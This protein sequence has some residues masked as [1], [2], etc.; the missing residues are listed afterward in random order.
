MA[1]S[2]Q[3]EAGLR[4]IQA[5]LRDPDGKQVFRLNGFAGTGKTTILKE[6]VNMVKGDTLFASFT[7]KAAL[8]MRSKGCEGASTIH[9]LIYS[10]DEDENGDVQFNLNPMSAVA[11]AGLTAIDEVSMVNEVLGKDL[12]SF[13]TRVLVVGDDAQLPPVEGTG[14]F[15]HGQTFLPD[16]MLT[17][18]HRQAADNPIIKLATHVREGRKLQIGTYG[19][20]RVILQS[21]VTPE[22]VL[23]ADQVL[24]GM[25][26]TRH[27]FNR[28]IRDLKGLLPNVPV[29]GDKLVCLKNSRQKGLLNGG[30]WTAQKVVRNIGF[31][32]LMVAPEDISTDNKIR[33]VH[34]R[35]EFFT[36]EEEKISKE[37]R[38][39]TDEFTFGYALT[40][41]KSQGSAWDSTLVYDQ[42][43][44]FRE[45]A[46][47]HLYTAITRAAKS[48]TIAI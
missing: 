31:D 5:W 29:A 34:V 42:S 21:E 22:M 25:N 16:V 19:E 6:V 17:K 44:V 12:L 9:S 11:D 43:S 47:A 41:H 15:T 18:I 38:R 45:H 1:W 28:R 40:V 39:K 37:D 10:P 46:K 23:D 8:V 3:Q 27:S 2:P 32:D 7:G 13:G 26:K 4:D 30:L 36:G 14:Y 20:S 48:I 35:S 33:K 24:V